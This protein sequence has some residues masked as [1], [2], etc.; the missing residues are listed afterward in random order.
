MSSNSIEAPG[1]LP[2]DCLKRKYE[3]NRIFICLPTYSIRIYVIFINYF[4]NYAKLFLSFPCY[5]LTFI[6]SSDSLMK[7][8]FIKFSFIKFSPVPSIVC[9]YLHYMRYFSIV[10]GSVP[11][12]LKGGLGSI[13][14][15]LFK[16][17]NTF[18]IR[19][20]LKGSSWD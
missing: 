6:K 2:E 19:C 20:I 10:T 1:Q 15:S 18:F 16:D 4:F 17:V 12:V 3:S 14:N 7:V 5:T 9:V 8:S 13:R 11:K